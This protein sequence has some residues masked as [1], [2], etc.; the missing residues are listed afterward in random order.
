MAA[1]KTTRSPRPRRVILLIESSR[2]MDAD[3]CWESGPISATKALGRSCTGNAVPATSCPAWCGGG[4]ATASSPGSRTRRRPERWPGWACRSSICR[5]PLSRATAAMLDTD[6]EACARLAA[7]HFLDRGFRHFGYCGYPGV[8]FSDERGEHF[9]R[10]LAALGHKAAVFAPTGRRAGIGDSRIRETSG[11]A[12]EPAIDNWLRKQPRPLAVFACNDVRGRQVL[13]ACARRRAGARGSCRA[14][15]QQRR[16]D[17]RLVAA[18][19]KQHQARHVSTGVGGGGRLGRHDEGIG[20]S[21]ASHSDSSP[22]SRRSTFV[23]RAGLG[24]RRSGR[25]RCG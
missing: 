4:E 18:A 20:R 22:G 8:E 14:R 10:H 6:P 24:R 25:R 12:A 13:A 9:V 17:L 5:G 19:A 21:H 2:P 15:G 11:E 7:D 3:V 16:G 1:P 23:R